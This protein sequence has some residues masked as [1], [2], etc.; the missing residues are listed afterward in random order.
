MLTPPFDELLVLREN[1]VD[2]LIQ[3]VLW[4]LSNESRVGVQ[5]FI[6][7]VIQPSAVLHQVLASGA[8]LDER[9]DSSSE[10]I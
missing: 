8:W 9:H 1:G 10:Q 3:N 2:Q 5:R 7:L 4:L 6:V